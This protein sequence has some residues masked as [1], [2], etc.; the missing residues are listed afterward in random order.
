MKLISNNNENQFAGEE[1]ELQTDSLEQQATQPSDPRDIQQTRLFKRPSKD[2]QEQQS[3]PYLI[4]ELPAE[5]RPSQPKPRP[6]NAQQRPAHAQVNRPPQGVQRSA[7]PRP[8]QQGQA[9]RPA[10][11][12]QRPSQPRP[13]P[14]GQQPRPAQQGQ[15]ARPATGQQRPSQPRPRPQTQP[16]TA[17]VQPTEMPAEAAAQPV[18]QYVVQVQPVAKPVAKPAPAPVE[19]EEPI[20]VA[21][22]QQEYEAEQP[23]ESAFG[24]MKDKVRSMMGDREDAP[25]DMPNREE[26]M[27]KYPLDGRYA[28]DP[29]FDEKLEHKLRKKKRSAIVIPIAVIGG[30]LLIVFAI[31]AIRFFASANLGSVKNVKVHEATD[32]SITLSWDQVDNAA[33]YHVFQKKD[34][35]RIVENISW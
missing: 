1:Q 6:A 2:G 31:L 14:Q 15:P 22:V 16:S 9:A 12:Q 32:H 11:G 28:P 30:I 18:T 24:K 29:T 10:A 8:S 35:L 19:S 3:A 21:A 25:K 33:G 27:R 5:Q 13:R 4:E 34:T 17:A 20:V 23:K 26:K 7:R